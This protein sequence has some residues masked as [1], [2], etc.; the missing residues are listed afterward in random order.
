MVVE[1]RGRRRKKAVSAARYAAVKSR[2]L[3]GRE[4]RDFRSALPG[5]CERFECINGAIW[6]VQLGT[7][8]RYYAPCTA[9]WEFVGSWC[10][11]STTACRQTSG[12]RSHSPGLLSLQT[13][14]SK[15]AASDNLTFL[16][17]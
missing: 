11:Q 3:S 15:S 13:P 4:A 14:Q 12:V 6:R 8:V 9:T 10:S 2:R 16:G 7:Q 5:R 17:I 1:E